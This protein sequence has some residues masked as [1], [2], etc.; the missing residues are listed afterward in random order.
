MMQEQDALAE[1]HALA[2]LKLGGRLS[3]AQGI[4]LREVEAALDQMGAYEPETRAMFTRMAE[5][6]DRLDT[7]L[8]EVQALPKK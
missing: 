3:P 1:Y 6:A 2:D 8:A 4:R 5:V 7:L